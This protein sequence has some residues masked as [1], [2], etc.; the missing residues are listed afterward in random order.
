MH[1]LPEDGNAASW[2]K[3]PVA[4][5]H[6]QGKDRKEAAAIKATVDHAAQIRTARFMQ[7]NS[8]GD[9]GWVA[10]QNSARMIT[11]RSR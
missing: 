7:A 2:S 5:S 4:L 1:V 8:R 9:C 3:R 6:G 11:A 10:T